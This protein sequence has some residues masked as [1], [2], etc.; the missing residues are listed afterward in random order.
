MAKLLLGMGS[1]LSMK[2][3]R[4]EYVYEN[5]LKYILRLYV[6]GI[7][8]RSQDAI[9]KVKEICEQELHGFYELE[10]IYERSDH[11]EEVEKAS[12]STSI[13]KLPSPLKKLITDLSNKESVIVGMEIVPREWPSRKMAGNI[14]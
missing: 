13:R 5:G 10:V 8:S 3:N 6:T 14:S 4:T 7:S 1:V 9:R 12:V 2:E 11:A